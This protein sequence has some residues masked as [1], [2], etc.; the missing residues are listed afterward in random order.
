MSFLNLKLH[1]RVRDLWDVADEEQKC[2]G[3]GK[4]SDGEIDPLHR[5]QGVCVVGSILEKHI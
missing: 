2:E 3:E 4:D 1:I 5:L